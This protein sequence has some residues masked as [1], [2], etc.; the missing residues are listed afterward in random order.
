MEKR[1]LKQISKI[2]WLK[3]G[4]G[5]NKYFHAFRKAKNNSN[6]LNRFHTN[7]GNVVETKEEIEEEILKFYKSLMG[8]ADVEVDGVNI[9]VL[10]KGPQ[11]NTNQR[12]FLTRPVGEE[13]IEKSL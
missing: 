3:V 6:T 2:E 13:E 8:T 4:D 9:V 5:I 11:L 12:E 10:R 7:T 1:D